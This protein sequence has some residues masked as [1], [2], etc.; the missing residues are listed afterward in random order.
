MSGHAKPEPVRV[1]HRPPVTARGAGNAGDAAR[2][3]V[4]GGRSGLA[5][6][7]AGRGMAIR[8][9]PANSGRGSTR[10]RPR[11]RSLPD[12]GGGARRFQPFR[13]PC[14]GARAGP[15]RRPP[16]GSTERRRGRP[17]PITARL[18]ADHD[19]PSCDDS[20]VA[21][22]RGALGPTGLSAAAPYWWAAAP[23]LCPYWARTIALVRARPPI[24]CQR[25][26]RLA[27]ARRIRR[28]PPLV[29]RRSAGGAVPSAFRH[30]DAGQVSRRHPRLCPWRA[31]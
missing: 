8:R 31:P 12:R 26:G 7:R 2:T 5:G 23:V 25:G 29:R 17:S 9:R 27:G 15:R 16:V 19:V 6:G 3:V 4:N 1:V 18:S 10:R 20:H 30:G 28:G 13:H 22:V 11:F 24:P 14:C 21:S